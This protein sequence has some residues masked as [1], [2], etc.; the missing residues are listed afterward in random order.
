MIKNYEDYIEKVNQLNYY[1]SK[2]DEGNPEISDKEW[3]DLYFAIKEYEKTHVPV[4]FSPSQSISYQVVNS[5]QKVTHSHPMLSLD[6]TKDIRAIK[7]FIKGHDWIVMAKMDG[8]TCSL[9]YL[10]G[11]L[12][13]AET[14]GNGIIG[15]NITHNAKV[16][17]SIPKVIDYKDEL[18]VDGEIICTYKDFE[19]F[20][21]TYKNPRNFASGSIRLLDAKECSRRHLTFIAWDVIKGGEYPYLSANLSALHRYYQKK[22]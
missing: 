21:E 10:D 11:K 8:L 3:D 20:K 13:S 9:R 22:K 7:S 17:P 2:Y 14:R 18:I 16:I 19:E 6:K 4:D 1:T 15:E 5:L 12:F